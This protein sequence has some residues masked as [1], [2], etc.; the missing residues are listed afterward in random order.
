MGCNRAHESGFACAVIALYQRA[1]STLKIWGYCPARW[2]IRN[3]ACPY[4][5]QPLP[6]AGF[7]RAKPAQGIHRRLFEGSR[8]GCALGVVVRHDS[9]CQFQGRFSPFGADS[10]IVNGFP[11]VRL[12]LLVCGRRCQ[13][14]Q[15]IS[16]R[17]ID[18]VFA[19]G[20]QQPSECGPGANRCAGCPV[21]GKR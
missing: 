13:K 8:R 2:L 7:R 4:Q 17:R 16:K 6:G 9:A 20:F 1:F 19:Q 18:Y 21:L 10:G 3:I 14:I 12:L 15:Q 11:P 5:V